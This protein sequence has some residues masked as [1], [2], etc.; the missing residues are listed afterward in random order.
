MTLKRLT[1]SASGLEFE[2][3]AD[4]RKPCDYYLRLL[5]PGTNMDQVSISLN[6]ALGVAAPSIG[7]SSE[8]LCDLCIKALIHDAVD[9]HAFALTERTH[10][11]R[12]SPRSLPP[13][14]SHIFIQFNVEP[15]SPPIAR[16]CQSHLR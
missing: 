12:F 14:S 3:E 13:I 6:I 8:P 16:H 9:L 1:P 2:L 11:P 4:D 7:E 5:E 15:S 10:I